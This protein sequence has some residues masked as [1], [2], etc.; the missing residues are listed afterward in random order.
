M[1]GVKGPRPCLGLLGKGDWPLSTRAYLHRDSH[2]PMYTC[3]HTC[4]QTIHELGRELLSLS[5]WPSLS[6]V[7]SVLLDRRSPVA[8]S[9][10][11]RVTTSYTSVHRARVRGQFFFS[12]LPLV[13]FSCRSHRDR[14]LPPRGRSIPEYE[15]TAN[16]IEPAFLYSE[17]VAA[18]CMVTLDR[19]RSFVNGTLL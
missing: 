13:K 7:C 1:A 19:G 17:D 15:F 9:G 2:L 10:A 4:N 5:L 6:L 11:L 12:S 18:T 14:F 16:S 3:W 8:E